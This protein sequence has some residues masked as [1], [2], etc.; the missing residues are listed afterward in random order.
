MFLFLLIS[1]CFKYKIT[2]KSLYIFSRILLPCIFHFSHLQGVPFSPF[3]PFGSP[4]RFFPFS[5]EVCPVVFPV[6]PGDAAAVFLQ[7]VPT[8]GRFL[9][10]IVFPT[11]QCLRNAII[12]RYSKLYLAALIVAGIA[13]P[14]PDL[15]RIGSSSSGSVSDRLPVCLLVR[16]YYTL[17]PGSPCRYS[18]IYLPHNLPR[19]AVWDRR[20]VF[21]SALSRSVRLWSILPQNCILV[22]VY[23]TLQGVPP[24]EV[25][26]ASVPLIG[27]ACLSP[28]S[29]CR[30]ALPLLHWCNSCRYS[31]L[32]F[33]AFLISARYLCNG[34]GKS[35]RPRV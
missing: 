35:T 21:L 26:A 14:C 16:V 22:R 20:A 33:A 5:A 31:K 18:K 30:V 27:S 23:Y 3:S 6:L 15:C 17:P 8:L 11:M 25:G 13:L 2:K 34:R 28:G 10:G 19:A 24:L 9:L 1:L 12:C 7:K 4:C 29:A 32:Y